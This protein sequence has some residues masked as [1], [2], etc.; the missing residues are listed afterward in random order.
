MA[1]MSISAFLQRD[2]FAATLFVAL[3]VH[4]VIILGVTFDYKKDL[5]RLAHSTM[6]ITI[7][8]YPNKSKKP[9][10]SDFL[11]QTSQE[12]GGNLEKR[13]KP[14]TRITPPTKKPATKPR[15]ERT[16][17][18]APKPQR[19][20]K[21]TITK[22]KTKNKKRRQKRPA[23]MLNMTADDFLAQSN[24]E[25]QRLTAELD[26]KVEAYAKR[27]KRKFVSAA[28]QEY[29][30]AAYLQSWM[31]KV[32]QIGT[33]NFPDEARRKRLFGSLVLHVSLR[34]NGTIERVIVK[35]SSGHQAL[36]DA[37]KRIVR[38]AAPFAPF[39]KNIASEIDIMD[40]TR[41]WRFSDG[42]TFSSR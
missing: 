19:A 3:L 1:N 31:R 40:I 35:R 38:L 8:R 24:L 36:D 29:K 9:D 18:G 14:K 16:G 10:Q 39:P 42:H 13:V 12:G 34:K 22:T 37:A 6:E 26:Q 33:L 21:K 32:E 7:V 2:P 5:S 20:A 11:A 28:T 4:S 25:V 30:Y 23:P 15:R 17:K 27:P 41:T